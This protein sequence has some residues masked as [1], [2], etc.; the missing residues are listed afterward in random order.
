[1]DGIYLLM[2]NQKKYLDDGGY[3]RFLRD[4]PPDYLRYLHREDVFF[5]DSIRPG[6]TVLDIGCGEGRTT[7]ALA[8]HV[9][10]KGHV[11][12]ID[13][14]RRMYELAKEKLAVLTNA[15]VR[16]MDARNIEQLDHDFG[17]I[18]FPFDILGLLPRAD[19]IPVLENASERLE[20]GGSILATVFSEHAAPGQLRLYQR[21]FGYPVRADEDYVYADAIDYAAERFSRE[22]ILALF[23][24]AGLKADVG[25]LTRMAYWIR[26]KT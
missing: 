22:K 13:F 7:A 15:E 14:D 3:E 16:F 17:Y 19:Q 25:R 26:A 4:I 2:V 5:R 24:K 23:E 8:L 1:M 10:P 9:G 18:V 20:K 6:S 11:I 12:G 21:L